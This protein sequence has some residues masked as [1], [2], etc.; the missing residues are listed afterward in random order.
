L[1]EHTTTLGVRAM[2]VDRVKA[3]RRFEPVVTR[4]GEV[5]LKLRGWQGRVLGAM[6]EYDDCLALARAAD[7]PVQLVWNEAHR[8]GERFIGQ[9]WGNSH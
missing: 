4:W 9:R 1:I 5:R 2:A 6:P 7:V 8:L 3:P